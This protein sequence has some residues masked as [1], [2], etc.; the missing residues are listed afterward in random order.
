MNFNTALL[1]DGVDKKEKYGSTL[2]PIYQTSAFFQQSAEDLAGIFGGEGDL[3]DLFD[4]F[5]PSCIFFDLQLAVFDPDLGAS[6]GKGAQEEDLGGVLGNV[7]KTARS[8]AARA[9]AGHIDISLLVD[10]GGAEEGHIQI[11]AVIEI[12]GLTDRV[13]GF[14][15]DGSRK[16]GSLQRDPAC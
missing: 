12:K 2:T 15:I 9:E 4:E 8:R 10:L 11:A 7:Y 5:N 3:L 16:S 6:V 1:H 14:W 13:D